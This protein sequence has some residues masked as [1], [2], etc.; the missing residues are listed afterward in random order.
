MVV[1]TE[2]KY[3]LSIVLQKKLLTFWINTQQ[4]PNAL[5]LWRVNK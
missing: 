5:N 2:K 1:L 4:A 3:I